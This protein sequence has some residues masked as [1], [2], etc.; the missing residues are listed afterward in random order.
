MIGF[1]VSFGVGYT[2]SLLTPR[3]VPEEVSAPQG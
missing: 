2:V 1:L 3:R